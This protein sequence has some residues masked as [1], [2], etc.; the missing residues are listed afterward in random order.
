MITQYPNELACEETWSSQ[1]NGKNAETPVGFYSYITS[2]DNDQ[3]LWL[4]LGQDCPFTH[5]SEWAPG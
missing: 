2:T 4:G 1:R 5:V 3:G